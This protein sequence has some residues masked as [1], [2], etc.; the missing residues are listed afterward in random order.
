M[1]DLLPQDYKE[2]NTL[3]KQHELLAISTALLTSMTVF[4]RQMFLVLSAFQD[5]NWLF[6]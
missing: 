2:K 1:S 3:V 4:V 5:I 6:F